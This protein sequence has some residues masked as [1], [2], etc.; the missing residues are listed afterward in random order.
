MNVNQIYTILILFQPL[1][2]LI[3]QMLQSRSVLFMYFLLLFF[4]LLLL[5]YTNHAKI[6][7][8]FW[9]LF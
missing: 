2:K 5:L 7:T 4:V 8:L 9:S 6:F 1:L 3:S